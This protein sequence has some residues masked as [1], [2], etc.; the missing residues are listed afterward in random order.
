MTVILFKSLVKGVFSENVS[1]LLLHGENS[2]YVISTCKYK[3]HDHR[4][5]SARD[6]LKFNIL[7]IFLA[8]RFTTFWHRHRIMTHFWP[9]AV[10]RLLTLVIVHML[11]KP[12]LHNNFY[13]F[14][15]CLSFFL[16]LADRTQITVELFAWL[17]SVR[18][19]SVTD[20]PWL[21]GRYSMKIYYTDN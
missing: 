2:T 18:F 14:R 12:G 11:I 7:L 15:K 5:K 10:V 17:L 8:V 13:V 21:K 1:W 20:V 19:S 6:A 3:L 9:P 4:Y 16:F